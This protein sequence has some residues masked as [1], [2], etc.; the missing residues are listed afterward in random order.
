MSFPTLWRK[1]IS[2]CVCTATAS[3]LVNG[4]PTEE[5]PMERGL[6]QALAQKILQLI[7][8][9][10]LRTTRWANVR[11]LRG[12]LV[13]FEKVSGLKVNFHKSMLVG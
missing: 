11:A 10:N 6:R 3:V 9:S 2:K 8:T 4:S 7:H 13:L 1:W 5:F 12:V